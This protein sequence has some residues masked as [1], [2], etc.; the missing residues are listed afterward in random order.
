M[1]KAKKNTLKSA[2]QNKEGR[3]FK[4]KLSRPRDLDINWTITRRVR[5]D[6]LGSFEDFKAQWMTHRICIDLWMITGI[7]PV[8][9]LIGSRTKNVPKARSILCW[10]L[11][12]SFDFTYPAIA[13]AVGIDHTTVIASSRRAGRAVEKPGSWERLVLADICDGPWRDIWL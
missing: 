4:R 1:T 9:I 5:V 10:L 12:N 2:I 7:S 3:T 6:R 13:R 11:R 8:A